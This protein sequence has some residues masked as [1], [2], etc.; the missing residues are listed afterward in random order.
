MQCLSSPTRDEVDK[1]HRQNATL[2][3]GIPS[4]KNLRRIA[5]SRLLLWSLVALS[6]IPLNWFCNSAVFNNLA[7]RDFSLYVV[8]GEFIDG[9]PFSLSFKPGTQES[10][11]LHLQLLQNSTSAWRRSESMN[12]L[13]KYLAEKFTSTHGDALKLY[14]HEHRNNFLLDYNL[15]RSQ[16]IDTHQEKLKPRMFLPCNISEYCNIFQ[17]PNSDY[18]TSY[19]LEQPIPEHC[20]LQFSA[21]IMVIVI[22]ANLIKTVC[23]GFIAWQRP[24]QA[25]VTIGDAIASFLNE[26]DTTT[27]GNCLADKQTNIKRDKCSVTYRRWEALKD[28]LWFHAASK[29]RWYICNMV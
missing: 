28:R 6:S 25:L 16:F 4:L 7:N 27:I 21:A 20:R 15:H 2:D 23:M 19:C 18:D 5:S 13:D 17:V 10:D 14:P 12:C 8:T 24:A 26:P 9:A 1:A 29:W 11:F 22:I 3:I